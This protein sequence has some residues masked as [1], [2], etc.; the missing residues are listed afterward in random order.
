MAKAIDDSW[1]FVDGHNDEYRNTFF[2][3]IDGEGQFVSVGK[4]LQE[5]YPVF[6]CI[7]VAITLEGL[8]EV[9][10]NLVFLL[11]KT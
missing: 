6:N 4:R 9:T 2:E 7:F 10:T 8:E 3:Y 11:I 1:T 5:G